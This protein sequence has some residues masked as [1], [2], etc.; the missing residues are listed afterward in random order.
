MSVLLGCASFFRVYI[1]PGS[2]FLSTVAVT[3][4]MSITVVGACFLGTFAPIIL[5]RLG[6]DPCNCASPALA[7]MTDVSGVL[8]LCA[9]SSVLLGSG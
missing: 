5:D 3:L 8:I 1:T 7:T 6:L 9:I 4:A 2:T